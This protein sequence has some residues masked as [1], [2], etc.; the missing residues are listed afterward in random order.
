VVCSRRAGVSRDRC[1]RGL[2]LEPERR[3]IA[4]GGPFDRLRANG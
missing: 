4:E 1:R 3:G 2:T